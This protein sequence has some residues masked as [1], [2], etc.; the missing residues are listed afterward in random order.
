LRGRHFRREGLIEVT[1]DIGKGGKSRWVAVPPGLVAV[2]AEIREN[3]EP[4]HFVLPAQ[5]F[6]D[7]GRNTQRMGLR[8]R[9]LSQQA[10]GSLVK[11][12]AARA[13]VAGHVTARCLRHANAQVMAEFAGVYMASAQLG[14]ADL[15]TT[16]A[17][18]A[19]ATPDQLME[20]ARGLALRTSGLF[21]LPISREATTGIEPV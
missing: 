15:R 8:T 7:V 13:N 6:R 17:D 18:L 14:H 21:G 4:D 1:P 10:L 2:V 20:A 5:R 11:A 16:Q 19:T 9:D 3:V 12:V